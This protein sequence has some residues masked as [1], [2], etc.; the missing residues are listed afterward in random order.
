MTGSWAPPV[1]EGIS[2]IPPSRG[3]EWRVRRHTAQTAHPASASRW[4]EARCP[5]PQNLSGSGGAA[6]PGPVPH[7]GARRR[8]LVAH[9]VS[10]S[11]PQRQKGRLAALLCPGLF[12]RPAARAATLLD[13][14][15]CATPPAVVSRL[16][17]AITGFPAPGRSHTPPTTLIGLL[18]HPPWAFGHF[19]GLN[20]MPV[21]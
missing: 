21:K 9:L 2:C 11:R 12:S 19:I 18:P 15:Q 5:H 7:R 4:Q 13:P 6:P 3:E 14:P 1:P 16:A 20:G 10:R 17:S 8:R